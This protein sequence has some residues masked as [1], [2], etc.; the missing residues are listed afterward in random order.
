M[1]WAGHVER[2]GRKGMHM[3]EGKILLGRPRHG[4]VDNNE[5]AWIDLAQDNEAWGSIKCWK[6]F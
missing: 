4:W 5:M 2:K 1:R 6:N 3:P